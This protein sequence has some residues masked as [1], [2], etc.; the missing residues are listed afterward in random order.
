[1]KLYE[2]TKSSSVREAIREMVAEIFHTE[3]SDETLEALVAKLSISDFIALDNA[4]D[5]G[6]ADTIKNIM[7][8]E[9]QLEY[10]MGG[11]G[12]IN[13]VAQSRSA[14]GKRPAPE[15]TQS[16]KRPTGAANPNYS[17]NGVKDDEADDINVNVSIDDE[18]ELE[19]SNVIDFKAELQR[20][21]GMTK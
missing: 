2:S 12:D 10:S 3:I 16:T 5:Q 14:P 1:M 8:P 15:K 7:Q 13:S 9:M 21:A 19:E 11:R 17:G 4:W 18:E 20:R 6:D